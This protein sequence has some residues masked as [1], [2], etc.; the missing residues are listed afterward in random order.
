MVRQAHHADLTRD[1]A[2]VGTGRKCCGAARGTT[3]QTTSAL[4]TATGTIL[5]IRTTT[6]GSGVWLVPRLYLNGRKQPQV[7]GAVAGATKREDD[8]DSFPATAITM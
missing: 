3:M 7:H 5:T 1:A 8:H 4:L 6:T 2:A